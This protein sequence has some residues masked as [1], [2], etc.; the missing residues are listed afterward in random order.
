MGYNLISSSEIPDLMQS[1]QQKC[2]VLLSLNGNKQNKRQS[3]KAPKTTQI[4][5]DTQKMKSN[6]ELSMKNLE[7]EN[8]SALIRELELKQDLSEKKRKYLSKRVIDLAGAFDPSI[9]FPGPPY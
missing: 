3:S 2:P 7:Q 1:N 4:M 9:L 8:S 6:E 5:Q